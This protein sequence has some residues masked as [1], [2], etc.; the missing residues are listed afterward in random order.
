[1]L[2]K[3]YSDIESNVVLLGATAVEDRL[4]DDVPATIAQLQQAGIKIWMLTGDKLETAENIGESCKL[5]KTENMQRHRLSTLKQVQQFCTTDMIEKNKKRMAAGEMLGLLVEAKALEKILENETF[6]ANFLK[7]SKTAEAVIC[8]RVSPGQK[9]DVVALIKEDDD[10]VITLA[11]GDGANDVSMIRE[12]H[13]GVGLF[14]NEGMSAVNSSD[15]ALGEF[16]MLWRLLLVHGRLYYFRNAE[17]VLYFFYKNFIMTLPQFMYAFYCGYSGSTIYEDFYI[18][19][20]NLAFT[21][22]PL[23]VKATFE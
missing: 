12:A 14:G 18:S 6:K 21:I 7:I 17:M 8:C 16:R 1:M 5:I 3:I 22:F 4:Q 11:I 15:F 19:F 23:M 20:F 9:A 10:E 2:D 13:I